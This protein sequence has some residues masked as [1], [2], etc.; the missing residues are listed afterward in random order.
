M[1]NHTAWR[2]Y[3]WVAEYNVYIVHCPW[4]FLL[5]SASLRCEFGQLGQIYQICQPC[6]L[7]SPKREPMFG[8]AT[9]EQCRFPVSTLFAP[10]QTLLHMESVECLDLLKIFSRN[11]KNRTEKKKNTPCNP[12]LYSVLWE[13]TMTK[14]PVRLASRA[15]CAGRHGPPLLCLDDNNCPVLFPPRDIHIRVG[16]GA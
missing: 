2:Q 10:R 9:Y 7:D 12:S 16:P 13:K 15:E 5:T 3:S 14:V 1:D 8:F 11:R 4:C 6:Q